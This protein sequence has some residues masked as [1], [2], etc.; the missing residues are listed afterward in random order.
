MVKFRIPVS[1]WSGSALTC[2]GLKSTALCRNASLTGCASVIS[3][4]WCSQD[5]CPKERWYSLPQGSRSP[6]FTSPG[7]LRC[8]KEKISVRYPYS[9]LGSFSAGS[10]AHPSLPI[11]KWAAALVPT[12]GDGERWHRAL[13]PTLDGNWVQLSCIILPFSATSW[14]S[15]WTFWE[16]FGTSETLPLQRKSQQWVCLKCVRIKWWFWC[17]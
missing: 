12:Q 5:C 7:V 1:W 11:S 15:S 16:N 13:S 17:V 10:V 14:P 6:S 3:L 9:S 8:T 2:F 4:S